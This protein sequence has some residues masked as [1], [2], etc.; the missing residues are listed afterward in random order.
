MLL[1]A[2][3]T[4]GRG[5]PDVCFV[6]STMD[7]HGTTGHTLWDTLLVVPGR[8]RHPLDQCAKTIG[9]TLGLPD[10]RCSVRELVANFSYK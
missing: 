1:S 9:R 4:Y 7:V 2:V 5:P 8:T 3:R 10:V 6:N